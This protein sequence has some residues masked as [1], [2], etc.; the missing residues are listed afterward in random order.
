M[1]H[2][3]VVLQACYVRCTGPTKAKTIHKLDLCHSFDTG[4]MT[5]AYL[6]LDV[7]ALCL[8]LWTAA[9]S[10]QMFT[11]VSTTTKFRTANSCQ[12]ADAMVNY[13]RL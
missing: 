1:Q 6:G 13:P 10:A 8:S 4:V 12:L 7:A 9:V 5:T 3:F 11:L 2:V